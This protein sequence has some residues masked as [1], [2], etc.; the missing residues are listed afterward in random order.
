MAPVLQCPDCGTK[1]PLASIGDRSAFPCEGC[2]RPLKVPEAALHAQRPASAA[3]GAPAEAP[4]ARPAR[5]VSTA[6]A[7]RA[8]AGNGATQVM[9]AAAVPGA[10]PLAPPPAFLA[11]P[12]WIRLVL[13][14][15]AVPLSFVV[16]FLIARGFGAFTS[17]QLQD[18]FLASNVGRFWPL[19][20]LLPFVALMTAGIVHGG[21]LVLGRR[22]A[23]RQRRT[24][25]RTRGR[26]DASSPSTRTSRTR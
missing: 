17:Q 1:H 14:V 19:V 13:W 22:G 11:V 24:G 20:R 23:I 3:V 15:V 8:Y 16:V 5:T 18:V 6:D 2:G 21:V 4:A 9:P 12:W 10:R 26:L 25:S 7:A